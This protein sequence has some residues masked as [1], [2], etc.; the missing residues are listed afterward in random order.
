M[1]IIHV[2][3]LGPGSAG[4][5]TAETA[6]LLSV[7]T[8][9]LLRTR[10][11]PAVAEIPGSAAFEDCDDLY[12][13][14]GNFAEVYASIAGRVLEAA[15]AGDVVYA[16]PGHPLVAE[17]SVVAL[18]SRAADWGAEVRVYPA[19]SFADA[20]AAALGV[21][22]GNVQ[23]CGAFDLR[24][25][26]QRPALI[27]QVYDRDSATALKLALLETY[28]PDHRIRVLRALGT[29]TAEVRELPLAELDHGPAGYL[30]SVFVAALD[31]LADVRRLDGV[32]AV[33]RRLHAPDGCPWDR[34]QSH[35]SLRSHL[36]EESYEV[37]A[38]IDA[39]DPDQLAEELGDLLLQVLMHAAV[40]EREG[41]FTLGD[42]TEHIATK[43]IRRHPHVFGAK[44]EKTSAQVYQDWEALKKAEKPGRSTLEGVP[45]TLPAL[46][47]AQS[48]Q[49]RA[50]RSGF[51]WAGMEGHLEK[52]VEELAEFAAAPDAAAREDEFGDILF[53][54]AGIGRRLGIDSEQA[55][56]GANDK[57]RRRFGFLEGA[58]EAR[59][60]PL[61]SLG[62]EALLALWDEAKHQDGLPG[63][64]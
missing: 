40:G 63:G 48:L 5:L 35:A 31:P 56:R 29:P 22:F 60:L 10:R 51:A 32:E 52:L 47:A 8:R 28:P 36:L 11:H 18:L 41:T 34:E 62:P 7:G 54:V 55:L 17:S 58:A 1:N 27:S 6:A 19:V 33:V 50:V 16:V 49:G 46:A 23:L 43:L 39:G 37:L 30:D 12:Q 14:G 4:L 44:T 24:I 15:S 13:A 45:A 42:V 64:P 9:V 2:V 21:D 57:F 26:A 53:V 20:A 3:G 61:G 59:G 25:D 38:A